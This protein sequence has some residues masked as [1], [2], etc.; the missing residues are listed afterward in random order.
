MTSKINV[1]IISLQYP[2]KNPFR[3]EILITILNKDI[4]DNYN[5][6]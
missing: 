2:P 1:V 5:F 4:V 6:N 3:F